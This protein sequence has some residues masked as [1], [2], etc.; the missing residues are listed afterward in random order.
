[1]PI[2]LLT[3]DI[4]DLSRVGRLQMTQGDVRAKVINQ[5]LKINK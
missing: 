2:S 3:R 5:K 4:N 1:M